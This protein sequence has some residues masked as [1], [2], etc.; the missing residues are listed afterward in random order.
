MKITL[1]EPRGFCFGVCRALEMLDKIQQR[2]VYVLHEIVH[3]QAVVFKYK[4]RGFIFVDDLSFVPKGSTLVFSAHGV[5][6]K[7]EEEARKK[8]LNIIDTTCPFVKRVHN[9]VIQLEQ[10]HRTIILIGKKNHAEI[11]GTAGQVKD[12]NKIFIVSNQEDVAQLPEFDKVGITTQTTLSQD[13][14]KNIIETIKQK[15]NNC[16]LQS[17]ICQATTQRQ[18]ALKQ[19]CQNN[20]TILVI[21]DKKSSNCMRLIEIARQNNRQVHLIEKASDINDLKLQGN[22][23]ITAAASAPEEIVQETFSLLQTNGH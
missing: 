10:D 3:N 19:A 17:G 5:S 12:T 16:L 1:I 11:I 13:E 22:I 20:D 6:K 9:W 23:A 21:G 18:K 15:Y 7:I 8:N 14:T 2:P 4:Q